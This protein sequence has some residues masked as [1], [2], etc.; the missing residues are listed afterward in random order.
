MKSDSFVETMIVAACIFII[1]SAIG[2]DVFRIL[3]EFF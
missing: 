3:K 2:F 1:L